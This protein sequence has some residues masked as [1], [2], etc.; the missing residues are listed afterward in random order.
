MPLST[1][2]YAN[3]DKKIRDTGFFSEYLPPCFQLNSDVFHHLPGA[4]CDLIP[5]YNFNMSRFNQNDARR[6]ISIPEIGAYAVTHAYMKDHHIIKDLV[7]FTAGNDCSFSPILGEDNS[8][9]RHEQSYG[10]AGAMREENGQIPSNYI[11]NL[12]TKIIR[13]SG[14]KKV[15]KLDISNFFSSFY[16]H[17]IPVI[18]LGLDE[19]NIQYHHHQNN[20]ESSELYKT[21]SDLDSIYRRQN[22]NQTNG[23][24]VGPLSSKII[25]E[26]MMTRID[27]DLHEPGLNYSRYV[28]D[29]EVYLHSDDEEQVISKFA[30]VLKKYGFT[31]NYEKT[32][33]LDF[34][35]YVSENLEKVISSYREVLSVRPDTS[36]VPDLM[37]LFN[38]FFN[39][40]ISGTKGAIRYLL[41]S[42]EAAPIH[43]QV[44]QDKKLYRAYLFTI[45]TNNDRSLT[46]ACSLILKSVESEP[47]DAHEKEQLSTML[48]ACL[49]KEYDLEVIWILYILLET[50]TLSTGNSLIDKIVASS[51][52][53]AQIMLLRKGILSD[54]QKH[55]LSENARS[56]ILIYELYTEGILSEENLIRKLN[57]SK[58]LIM[59]RKMKTNHVHFCY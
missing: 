41:K 32:E 45:L 26:G 39:F 53:L 19:T 16:L 25:A 40:E 36:S 35:Y 55:I 38:S 17:M 2:E 3:L 58:N 5:P 51:N 11:S 33:I 18:I 31:L 57:L 43:F 8:I 9:M 22:L 20:E 42:I 12:A 1:E 47:L 48:L 15:L 59:Y 10:L 13:A 49:S 23:L 24:L 54:S 34:P 52:E 56:W 44:E 4:K 14:A 28:D 21:Y 6:T 46:K 27:Q 29:Y 30:S 7:E 50:Q 37:S